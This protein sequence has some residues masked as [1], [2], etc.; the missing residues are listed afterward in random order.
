[1]RSLLQF[2]LEWFHSEIRDGFYVDGLMKCCW[3]AGMEVFKEVERVCSRHGL[4]IFADCGTLLGAVRHGGF[5]PWDDDLD[6]AMLRDDYMKFREYAKEELPDGYIVA[7][8]HELENDLLITWVA[9]GQAIYTE[10]E[11]LQKYHGFPYPASIDIFPLDYI[12]PDEEEED[13]R[14]IVAKAVYDSGSAEKDENTTA[15]DLEEV[16]R[17]VEELTGAEIDRNCSIRVQMYELAEQLYSLYGRDGAEEVALMYYWTKDN[18]H[19]Y[20]IRLFDNIIRIPFENLEIPVPARYDE[21]LKIEYGDYMRIVRGQAAHNYPAYSAYE[22]QLE[23]LIDSGRIPYRFYY[24]K[25]SELKRKIDA[26]VKTDMTDRKKKVLF[27]PFNA[28]SWNEL[29]HIWEKLNSDNSNE[30]SVMPVPWFDRFTFGKNYEA[31]YDVEKL[32]EKLHIVDYKEYNLEKEHPDLIYFQ[33]PN[34]FYDYTVMVHPDYHSDK[35]KMCTE[36]LVCVPYIIP[37]EIIASD[38]TALKT[39]EYLVRKPGI[40]NADLVIVPSE[41]LRIC[42]IEELVRFAGENSRYI[43]EEKIQAIGDCKEPC[44][45]SEKE[46]D[47]ALKEKIGNRK[48]VLYYISIS[49]ILANE[50][51]F[52]RKIRDVFSIFMQSSDKI[53]LIWY[54]DPMIRKSLPEMRPQLWEEYSQLVEE[55]SR[56][57]FVI[58]DENINSNTA[59]VMADAYYGDPGPYV[60]ECRRLGKPVMI[61]DCSIVSGD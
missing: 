27:I 33:N 8:Y 41:N 44:V 36:K 31:H 37:K 10:E 58:N 46:I 2:P 54:P 32:P 14:K 6:F 1:M 23:N 48:A 34:D 40:M 29:D 21:V 28:E 52:L 30:V 57:D 53:T 60:E 61:E 22:T 7:D 11:W 49:S 20:D 9:N 43:W 56:L 59:V 39:L 26:E 3:A 15:E 12:S 17:E 47:E 38:K 4:K 55:Y 45:I 42:Y 19:K 5:I 35:L 25:K 13:I 18:S 16:I 50:D 24:D 51:R